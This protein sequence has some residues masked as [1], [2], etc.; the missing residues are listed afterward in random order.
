MPTWGSSG[1]L[2]DQRGSWEQ[3][4]AALGCLRAQGAYMLSL[5]CAFSTFLLAI[6]AKFPLF[7]APLTT[8]RDP[9]FGT[10]HETQCAA[11]RLPAAA[12]AAAA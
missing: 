9:N 8:L 6:R 11:C 12:A 2:A 4:A 7:R 3:V 1:P 10:A 5:G